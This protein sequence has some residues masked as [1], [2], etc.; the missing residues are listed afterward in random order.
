MKPVIAEE[1]K[2]ALMLYQV[3][4]RKV[5]DYYH[6]DATKYDFHE[7]VEEILLKSN[8]ENLPLLVAEYPHRSINNGANIA[9]TRDERSGKNDRQVATSFGKYIRRHFPDLKDHEVRDYATKVTTDIFELWDNPD[10]IV[11]SIQAGPKSC[12]QWGPEYT[13]GDPDYN[14]NR[15][16]KHP[17][18]VYAP[19]LGWKAA[20]RLRDSDRQIQGRA[21]VYDHPEFG[22][23]FV[24]TY[25]RCI[26]YSYSDEFLEVW[27]KDQGYEHWGAWPEDTRLK[28][29]NYDHGFLAPYL[30]GDRQEVDVVGDTLRVVDSGSY[31]LDSTDGHASE[32]DNSVY[33]NCC[34]DYHDEADMTSTDD[35]EFDYVCR[36][37]FDN[38]FVEAIGYRGRT[39]HIHLNNA[40]YVDSLQQYYDNDYLDENGIVELHNGEY[41]SRDDCIEHARTGEYYLEAE[42]K[43]DTDMIIIDDLCYEMDEVF[44]CQGSKDYY[45]L[46]EV[47]P[48]EIDGEFYHPDYAPEKEEENV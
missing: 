24:R 39:V 8:P 47:D 17:Y 41:A 28:Y 22:K 48:V 45:P 16:S 29:I 44:F 34:D 5:F 13:P 7:I 42:V 38:D 18:R 43:E 27:L 12:M 33:C 46:D 35:S 2:A 4:F 9:Y 32:E 6:T 25:K 37:C 20:V 15:G 10:D 23:G 1:N 21:L 14:P 26:D 11:R 30:D 3:H 19:E 36:W 40:A 31:T